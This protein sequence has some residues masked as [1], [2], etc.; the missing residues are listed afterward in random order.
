MTFQFRRVVTGHDAK[1]L[2]VVK[3]DEIVEAGERLPGYHASTVWC[4]TEF[5]VNNDEGASHAADP[6]PGSRVLMRIGE[7]RAD[8]P[9]SHQMHRTESLDY[10]V[11]LS[12]ECDMRLDGGTTVK[13]LKAGD[14][15]IQRG[16]NHAWQ[17]VGDEPCRLLFV[18]IDAEPVHCGDITLRD[19]VAEAFKGVIHPQGTAQ[20][21]ALQET[22][23]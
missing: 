7:M 17:P 14:V 22:P 23:K 19:N 6:A 21:S 4:T 5:P 12:G 1:G 10:A 11:I 3:A 18:L 2:A 9:T 13:R 15:I 16:T 8:Q 20:F